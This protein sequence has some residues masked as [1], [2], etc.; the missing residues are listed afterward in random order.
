MHWS[1]S[2]FA[3]SN[4]GTMSVCTLLFAECVK[5]KN[6]NKKI[7]TLNNE[8]TLA[9]GHAVGIPGHTFVVSAVLEV[10]FTN[11][12]GATISLK[13]Q[14]EVFGFLHWLL[15]MVP[16]DLQIQIFEFKFLT[17]STASSPKMWDYCDR[18]KNKFYWSHN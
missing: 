18:G 15:I 13:Q 2:S 1:Y 6:R 5:K 3:L 14:L 11:D 7:L 10:D 16:D 4:C 8:P 12:E 17:M 9:V